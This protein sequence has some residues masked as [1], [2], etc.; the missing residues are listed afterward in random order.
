MLIVVSHCL[1]LCVQPAGGSHGGEEQVR[2]VWR[3]AAGGK[4]HGRPAELSGMSLFPLSWFFWA[5]LIQS[6][7]WL[8]F[9]SCPF[10]TL[11]QVA[12][13]HLH[14]LGRSIKKK[15]PAWRLVSI[16]FSPLTF[17]LCI[18]VTCSYFAPMIV[19]PPWRKALRM[20]AGCCEGLHS[21]NESR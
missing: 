18:Y 5:I 1:C 16:H 9:A 14:F 17:P 21:R 4:Q 8:I 13:W 7:R 19:G 20:P 12:P 6:T 15:N 11:E 2:H 3:V 10:K